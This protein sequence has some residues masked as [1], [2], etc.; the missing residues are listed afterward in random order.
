MKKTSIKSNCKSLETSSNMIWFSK[1]GDN[2]WKKMRG[3]SPEIVASI[4]H[5]G[6]YSKPLYLRGFEKS[7]II[8]GFWKWFQ[9]L[10]LY[11]SFVFSLSHSLTFVAIDCLFF[12]YGFHSFSLSLFFFFL[13]FCIVA[14]LFN[15][16]TV[17]EI[18]TLCTTLV[19]SLMMQQCTPGNQG[20][21][22]FGK[23]WQSCSGFRSKFTLAVKTEWLTILRDIGHLLYLYTIATNYAML[24]ALTQTL[25]QSL[26]MT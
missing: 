12:K 8:A 18:L 11:Y 3:R 24:N 23:C 22:L 4:M 17:C 9:Y 20:I 13:F 25:R 1:R 26:K 7:T 16:F 14:V 2:A 5:T 19:W 21:Y 6:R 10:F 15:L